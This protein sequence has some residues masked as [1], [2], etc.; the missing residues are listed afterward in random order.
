VKAFNSAGVPEAV[1][2]EI[3]L[4][5]RAI[6]WDRTYRA[7]MLAEKYPKRIHRPVF[8]LDM[9]RIL[10]RSKVTL[11]SHIDAAEDY[12]GNARLYEATGVGSL[13]ITDWKKNLPELFDPGK[14]VVAYHTPEE[15]VEM[16][17]Y[18]LEHE[19]ERRAIAEAGQKRTLR[20][21]TYR[22][23]T[24]ELVGIIGKLL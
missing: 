21:H 20:D 16:I 2:E 1:L 15:C 6:Q 3:P 10:A 14:E 7:T 4:V 13:L 17:C 9:F 5:N 8:G 19:K 23:R 18:Y 12:A 24:L 11:N 22:Q